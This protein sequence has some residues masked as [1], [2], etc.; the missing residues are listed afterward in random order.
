MRGITLFSRKKMVNQ[1]EYFSNSASSHFFSY[2]T[3]WLEVDF[4]DEFPEDFI[5]T[6]RQSLNWDHKEMQE[7][8]V[9]LQKLINWLERDWREKRKTKKNERLEKR[10]GINIS[11]WFEKLP[12]DTREKVDTIVTTLNDSELPKET[13]VKAIEKLHQIIPEYPKYH[14]RHLHG[15]IKSASENDYQNKDY[16]RAFQEAVKRYSHLVKE[17]SGSESTSETSMMGKVFGKGRIL[18]VAKKFKKPN[19][20]DFPVQTIEDIEE[21]QK[22]LSMGVICGCRN[23]VNH[24]EIR[25]LR[26]SGL[27]TQKDCLDAL[28]LLS[29]LLSRLDYCKETDNTSI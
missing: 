12:N 9:H 19:G 1:P 4:I 5:A 22:Y 24:E 10:T 28:S 14:W 6:N 25:A 18:Q 13:H 29:H 2:L 8:R 3:G 27:F 16:Y 15:E 7:L 21:G 23:P 26:D 20:E 17:K 11:E